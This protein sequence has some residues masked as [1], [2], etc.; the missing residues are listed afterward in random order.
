MFIPR[1]GTHPPGL[2]KL[3]DVKPKYGLRLAARF[4]FV[5]HP[6]WFVWLC[7]WNMSILA[8]VCPTDFGGLP[9]RFGR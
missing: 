4:Q 5:G 8:G 6:A 2:N 1:I 7:G 3:S 9:T